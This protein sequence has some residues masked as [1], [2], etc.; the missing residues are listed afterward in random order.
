[1]AILD[2]NNLV[3]HKMVPIE[4]EGAR[5]YNNSL[6]LPCGGSDPVAGLS[7]KRRGY[8]VWAIQAFRESAVYHI[9]TIRSSLA[10]IHPEKSQAQRRVVHRC[11]LVYS[12]GN[13][14]TDSTV[15]NR[16]GCGCNEHFGL[17]WRRCYLGCGN[18]PCWVT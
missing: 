13:H 7:R 6:L 3:G 10:Y 1:V 18:V 16:L 17:H 5:G 15:R 8:H 14:E 12:D 4:S 9:P 2:Y 11:H